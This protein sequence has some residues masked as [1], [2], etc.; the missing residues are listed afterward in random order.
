MNS[1]KLL[2]C[3]LPV[4]ESVKQE[5]FRRRWENLRHRVDW[6]PAPDNAPQCLAYELAKSGKVME[7]GYG[8]QAGGGKTDLALGLAGTVFK[9]SLIMRREFPQLEGIIDRGNVIYPTRLV[10]GRKMR[11]QWGERTITLRSMQHEKD[12]SKQQG[13]GRDFMAFDEAAEF[14]E[15]GL[16]SVTGWNRSGDGSRTLVLY[17]FNP[18][19][20]SEGEWIVRYFAPWIDPDYPHE[21]AKPGEIRWFVHVSKAGSDDDEILEVPNGDPYEYEGETYL[22]ISRTFIAASRHDNP[23]LGEEYE[24]TLD[25]LP[26][27]LRTMVKKG[28]FHLLRQDDIWQ[29]I[30]TAWV[31]AAQK[32]WQETEKP[33]V[34]LRAIGVDVAHGGKDRTA[35]AKLYAN[36]FDEPIVYEGVDTPLGEDVVSRVQGAMEYPT[37]IG[38]DAVGYGASAAEQL[39][40]LYDVLK[41]NAGEGVR[42]L[43]KSEVYGFANLRAKMHWRFRE[44][45]D[46]ESGENICLPPSRQLRL[47]LCAP[48]YKIVGGN[49]QVEAKEAIIKRLGKSPDIGEA[50]LH[51][52]E[53][54]QGV[55]GGTMRKVKLA[56][57]ER[58]YVRT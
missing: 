17:M 53:V 42:E 24:R 9:R 52:W 36:W 7:I 23:F 48:R 47:E 50:F 10:E 57:R 2:R 38:I 21:H 8:G 18:P 5:A 31:L 32:R 40:N 4:P 41:I 3:P 45:L 33:P 58:R 12:W 16:R 26:E 43:D 46:P 44:A 15:R 11:W 28:V 55:Q 35:I 54:A 49:Y 20:T 37:R 39:D 51:A 1:L 14:P 22:P 29:V 19:T 34:K 13:Q 56:R 30:P 6:Q 27:P 25:A